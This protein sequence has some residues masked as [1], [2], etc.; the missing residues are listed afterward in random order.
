MESDNDTMEEAPTLT[1]EMDVQTKLE[2][3]VKVTKTTQESPEVIEEEIDIELKDPEADKAIKIQSGSSGSM[4]RKERV[5]SARPGAVDEESRINWSSSELESVATLLQAGYR[6]MK[7]RA[8]MKEQDELEI[9]AIAQKGKQMEKR[10]GI[11]LEDPSVIRS[12]TL[13]QAGFR[14][15][16]TRRNL[17]A[18]VPLQTVAETVVEEKSEAGSESE[19]EYTYEYEDEEE[20]ESET[21]EDR[22]VSPLTAIATN[23]RQEISIAGFRASALITTWLQRRRR[24]R[25]MTEAER[26]VIASR[27]QAGYKGLVTREAHR[28]EEEGKE[29]G[30]LISL[31][32]T[33]GSRSPFHLVGRI[34]V[35]AGRR[36]VRRK[37]PV[38]MR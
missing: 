26:D 38:N 31:R 37:Y 3:V 34:A 18:K 35:L 23:G 14:G 32:G 9:K 22:P 13:I 25:T 10:L 27:I 11:D 15:A 21:L 12:A 5:L 17:K 1:D 4:A 16:L 20:E 2:A 33:E 30:E 7:V 24:L 6:G 29:G 8:E 28:L 19:S 36:R